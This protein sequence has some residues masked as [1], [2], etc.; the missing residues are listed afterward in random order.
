[1]S[2]NNEIS[3]MRRLPV[4]HEVDVFVAGD[5][6]AGVAAAE[7]HGDTRQVAVGDLQQSLLALSACLPHLQKA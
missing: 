7:H 3:Y 5:G 6:S 2:D 4:R 1:M